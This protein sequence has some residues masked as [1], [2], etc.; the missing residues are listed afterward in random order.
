MGKRYKVNQSMAVR[1]TNTIPFKCIRFPQII[2]KVTKLVSSGN[3]SYDLM[4]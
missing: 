4:R 2:M 1:S 3:Y